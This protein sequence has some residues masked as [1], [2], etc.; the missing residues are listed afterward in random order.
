MQLIRKRLKIRNDG[1]LVYDGELIYPTQAVLSGDFRSV[2]DGGSIT[3]AYS[4]P[5]NPNYSAG[6]TGNRVYLCYFYD[7][8]THQNFNFDFT[9][10][11]TTFVSVATGPS[12]TTNVTCELLAPNT[13]E[14]T[15]VVEFKDMVTAHDS[16]DNHIGCYASTYGSTIPTNW[17]VTIGGKST[18][19]SGNAIVIRITASSSWTGNISNITCTFSP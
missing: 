1:L 2:T 14:D 11:G 4:A 9:I 12:G 10:S 8:S 7:S 18:A 19:T 17:G 5:D 3:Y 16:N 6:T 15:G 13:T